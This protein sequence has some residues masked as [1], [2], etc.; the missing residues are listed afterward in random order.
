MNQKRSNYKESM[1]SKYSD[2]HHL[3]SSSSMNNSL[4]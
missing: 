4:M 3:K 2:Y 1:N